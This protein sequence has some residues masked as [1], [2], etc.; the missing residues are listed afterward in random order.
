MNRIRLRACGQTVFPGEVD[1][2]LR[3]FQARQQRDD[4]NVGVLELVVGVAD[5][6][7]HAGRSP[8]H[9]LELIQVDY[10][11]HGQ[12]FA[13]LTRLQRDATGPVAENR[14]QLK[15]R[16]LKRAVFP[17]YAMAGQPLLLVVAGCLVLLHN[18]RHQPAGSGGDVVIFAPFFFGSIVRHFH[19]RLCIPFPVLDSR[20]PDK[21]G[22]RR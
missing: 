1:S 17:I 18:D 5:G 12:A 6:A 19:P 22:R 7:H 11:A 2:D 3:C 21:H 13:P 9:H 8:R 15:H 14:G 4:P 16:Y 20:V 10:Q